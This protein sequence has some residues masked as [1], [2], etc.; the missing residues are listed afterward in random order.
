MGGDVIPSFGGYSAD[1]GG[2]E[3]AGS[4]TRRQAVAL[5]LQPPAGAV[6]PLTLP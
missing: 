1:E 2:I 5:G 6:H 3:I 4:W